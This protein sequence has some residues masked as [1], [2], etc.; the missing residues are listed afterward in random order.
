MR[1]LILPLLLATLPV[2]TNAQNI[3][4]N[5]NGAAPNASAL[6]DID[7]S[8]IA[9]TKRGLLIPRMTTVE[10]NGIPAPATSLLVFNTSTA[11]FEYFDGAIW[12]PLL[13][14]STGW[15]LTGNAGTNPATNFMGTTDAQALRFRVNNLFAGNV[16]ATTR[17]RQHVR[18]RQCRGC[19]HHRCQQH[20]RR[21][22]CGCCEHHHIEQHLRRY[23]CW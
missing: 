16:S 21:P 13:S 5:V 17:A 9:G 2:L 19:E 14:N 4:I 10:R 6:L 11:Q 8:A 1:D 22:R 12:R 7:V 3:G 18:R 20:L 15:L 23:R